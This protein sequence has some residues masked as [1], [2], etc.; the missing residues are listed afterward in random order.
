MRSLATVLAGVG[1]MTTASSAAAQQIDIQYNPAA[2]ALLENQL[3]LTTDQLNTLITDEIRALYGLVDT[4][5][6]L[7]L[8]ANA[9]G[10]ANKGIGVD[11]ASN[12]DGWIF[13]VAFSVA[14]DAGDADIEDFNALAD[15]NTERAVPVAAGAQ[16]G[17]MLGY[18][19]A[20]PG[21]PCTRTLFIIR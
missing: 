3:D 20:R 18:T 2:R 11:Y 7:R 13:G 21:S 14:A 12:L 1:L 9:Q 4:A 17:L 16:I 15:G 5:T 10:M 19:V 6:F 8:S